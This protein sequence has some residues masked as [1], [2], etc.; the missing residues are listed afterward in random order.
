MKGPKYQLEISIICYAML[1]NILKQ[2]DAT[3]TG[4]EEFDNIFNLLAKLMINGV[5][6]IIKR[7]FHR[8]YQ[9]CSEELSFIRG[10]ID[11]ASSLRQ[12]S[13]IRKQLVCDFD[14]FTDNVPFNQILKTTIGIL[15]KAPY[16]DSRIKKELI[17]IRYHFSFIDEIR[18]TMYA[19]SCLKYN[20]NNMHYKML[21]NICELIYFGLIA[22]EEGKAL[23]FADFI[24][25][26]QMAVLYEKF[27]LNFYKKHL[28][29][30][31]Y[32]THSPKI[33]WGIDDGFKHVGLEY[34][35]QM[36]TDIVI[37]NSVERTQIIVDTKYYAS[38]LE[39]GNLGETKKLIP[40]NLYQICTY[41]NNSAYLGKVSGMLLYPTT[42]Q[43]LNLKY[44]IN[45]KIIKVKTLNL[46]SEWDALSERLLDIAG[47]KGLMLTF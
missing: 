41:V 20:R 29:V 15:I 14:E 36:R 46:A 8:E 28:P 12:Q 31:I 38:A 40:S 1:W 21:M 47:A 11:V 22:N 13:F 33:E 27:V 43:E 39:K 17:D 19:F 42:E 4:I 32:R 10:K 34:L 2:D 23:K 24:R 25:N 6:N 5:K 26:E 3:F 35:P 7:G 37:E 18:I 44:K 45:G 16:L 9:D 30:S